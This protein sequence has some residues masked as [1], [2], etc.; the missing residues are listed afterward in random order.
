MGML[1]KTKKNLFLIK[2]TV[3]GVLLLFA[4]YA[5]ILREL[6]MHLSRWQLFGVVAI[7]IVVLLLCLPIEKWCITLL[8]KIKSLFLPGNP[9][10][11]VTPDNKTPVNIRSDAYR[12]DLKNTDRLGRLPFL[13]SLCRYIRGYGEEDSIVLGLY[14][15]WGEG[16]TTII[17]AVI[18]EISSD[19]KFI[20]VEF[21][22]WHYATG[23]AIAKA[24]FQNLK[25]KLEAQPWPE[26]KWQILYD[27][28]HCLEFGIM[29]L[30]FGFTKS[31]VSLHMMVNDINQKLQQLDKKLLI[32]FDDIDRLEKDEVMRVFELTRHSANFKNTIYLLAFD[33]VTVR[34]I[35]PS[36][37]F[38]EKIVQI[39]I[40]LPAI[41]PHIIKRD[42][43][44]FLDALPQECLPNDHRELM[45]GIVD[46]AIGKNVKTLRQTKSYLNNLS[47]ALPMVYHEVNIIDFMVLEVIR[48][49]YPEVYDDIWTS[50]NIYVGIDPSSG[51]E[52]VP[53]DERRKRYITGLL[54]KQNRAEDVSKV[55]R[56]LGLIF[57]N[58]QKFVEGIFVYSSGSNQRVSDPDYIGKYFYMRVPHGELPDKEVD[59]VINRWNNQDGKAIASDLADY[60]DRMA[61]GPLCLSVDRHLHEL[62]G[63]LYNSLAKELCKMSLSSSLDKKETYKSMA[64]LFA[65]L[66]TRASVLMDC[67][68]CAQDVEFLA[69]IVEHQCNRVNQAKMNGISTK[70]FDSMKRRY[71]DSKRDVF[72]EL[73]ISDSAF[74][75]MW[76][77]AAYLQPEEMRKK[78]MRYIFT[79]IDDSVDKLLCFISALNQT[80]YSGEDS[81]AAFDIGELIPIAWR[82]FPKASEEGKKTIEQFITMHSG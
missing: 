35:L 43:V 39:G 18:D 12:K 46:I 34:N 25:L 7:V 53:K 62:S 13:A 58:F 36:P 31:E 30:N 11:P 28:W 52:R 16:K 44:E 54:E 45:E 67:I 59:Q 14:G 51:D 68:D 24:F 29:G 64:L 47:F 5:L 79:C 22:P 77:T 40:E 65:S 2:Q 48:E 70:Y 10:D 20:V 57:P 27:Y 55:L 4:L 33:P 3:V 80:G 17:H 69:I 1:H 23:D 50:N 6:F 82:I 78:L 32:V 8:L 41:E 66:E 38:I 75:R 19:G 49:Y 37:D 61:L 71:V 9:S 56:L 63:E 42:I 60:R 72:C 76:L 26:I 21:N 74:L 73:D 15:G 81:K